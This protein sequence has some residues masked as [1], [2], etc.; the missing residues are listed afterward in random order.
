MSLAEGDEAEI[1]GLLSVDERVAAGCSSSAA[2]AAPSSSSRRPVV[3]PPRRPSSQ[4]TLSPAMPTPP[5]LTSSARASYRA[6]LPHRPTLG[7]RR[8][9]RSSLSA[10]RDEKEPLT[11]AGGPSDGGKRKRRAFGCASPLPPLA[12]L[13]RLELAVLA[14][15]PGCWPGLR[16]C[17]SLSVRPVADD[18]HCWP[19]VSRARAATLARLHAAWKTPTK[20]APIPIGLGAFYLGVKTVQKRFEGDRA[21]IGMAEDGDEMIVRVR[22]PWQVRLWWAGSC[23]WPLAGDRSP[24]SSQP[25][26]PPLLLCPACQVHVMG[27]LPLRSLSRLWGYLNSFEVRPPFPSRPEAPAGRLAAPAR[28]VDPPPPLFCRRP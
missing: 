14:C 28:A 25:D 9:F 22:G 23:R 5:Q 13:L 1:E 24:M 2:P 4:A 8:G 26:S 19:C 10:K 27:A 11:G 20:W 16:V 21:D 18:V 17:P 3:E 7:F 6:Y 15:L 12:A